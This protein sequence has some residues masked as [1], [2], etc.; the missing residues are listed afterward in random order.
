MPIKI[1]NSNTPI[2]YFIE[3]DS[4][5]ESVFAEVLLGGYAKCTPAS[6]L[7]LLANVPQPVTVTTAD[8]QTKTYTF[9][10]KKSLPS[11]IFVQRWDDVLAINNNF[12]TNGGYIFTGYK[13]YRDNTELPST[14]GYIQ[15]PGGLKPPPVKYWAELTYGIDKSIG[16]CPAEIA[17]MQKMAAVYPNPVQRGQAVRIGMGE[18]GETGE[19]VMRLYDAAGNIVAAQKLPV[20]VADVV[21]PDT[22]GTYI[23]QA[24]VDGVAQTFKI[25]VVE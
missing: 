15:E 3:C 7:T 22:P 16:T 12:A 17:N 4:K 8:G 9:E 20:P 1:G 23:L 11:D 5:D 6:P 18:A 2:I 13:W 14:K 10:A 21:M 25:V 24:T 19:A